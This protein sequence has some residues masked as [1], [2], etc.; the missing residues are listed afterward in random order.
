MPPHP[1]HSCGSQRWPSP[2]RQ[3]IRPTASEDEIYLALYTAWQA[4]SDDERYHDWARSNMAAMS[5]L[6]TGVQLGRREPGRTLL[7][8]SLSDERLTRLDRIRAHY[9]PEGRFHSRMGR[10]W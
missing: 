3:D 10:P 7:R 4:E 9:D 1:A 8:R 5:E 6:H 2:Q